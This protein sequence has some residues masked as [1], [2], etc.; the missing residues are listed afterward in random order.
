MTTT[1][2]Q[3]Q[4]RVEV[5][6]VQVQGSNRDKR[7]TPQGSTHEEYLPRK[8]AKKNKHRTK[9]KLK[10]N[11]AKG[12]IDIALSAVDATSFTLR[13][14]VAAVDRESVRRRRP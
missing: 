8:Q 4:Q 2:S 14:Q 7:T 13:A 11:E 5:G 3:G 9:H 12:R 10:R 6:R 1:A